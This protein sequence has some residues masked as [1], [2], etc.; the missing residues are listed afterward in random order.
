MPNCFLL[1]V[2]FRYLTKVEFKVLCTKACLLVGL[3]VTDITQ[4]PLKDLSDLL[5]NR[6]VMKTDGARFLQEKIG[7]SPGTALVISALL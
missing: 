3:S 4:K 7:M 2:T 6:T 1:N 5:Y